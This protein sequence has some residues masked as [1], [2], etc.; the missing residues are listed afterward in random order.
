MQSK[1]LSSLR[2]E[3]VYLFIVHVGR[4]FDEFLNGSLSL[5]CCLADLI[6]S[7]RAGLSVVMYVMNS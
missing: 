5:S 7:V 3:G 4:F 2:T 6:C 1:H